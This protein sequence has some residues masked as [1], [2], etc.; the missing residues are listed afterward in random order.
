MLRQSILIICYVSHMLDSTQ[1]LQESELH[2]PPDPIND[3]ILPKH[4]DKRKAR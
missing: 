2:V 3:D 1:L 4:V